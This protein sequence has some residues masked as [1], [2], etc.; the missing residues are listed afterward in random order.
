[1]LFDC[2]STGKKEREERGNEGR[3]RE[4]R[5]KKKQR[6]KERERDLTLQKACG[7]INGNF[8]VECYKNVIVYFFHSTL[9]ILHVLHETLKKRKKSAERWDF[10]KLKPEQI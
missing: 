10:K 2:L 3:E 5:T 8:Y 7:K 6:K 1:M 4:G 9:V